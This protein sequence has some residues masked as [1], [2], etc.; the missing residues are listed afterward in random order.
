MNFC[1]KQQARTN[2]EGEVF[3][4]KASCSAM[5]QV[6]PGTKH[7]LS[8]KQTVYALLDSGSTSSF[9][10]TQLA[11]RLELKPMESSDVIRRGFYSPNNHSTM[12]VHFQILDANDSG[13]F[14]CQ[15][16]LVVEDFE[17]PKL[18]EDPTDIIKKYHHL[19]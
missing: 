15:N 12:T 8:Q 18:K 5:V 11:K 6:V 13:R 4:T 3:A 16:I 9:M 10:S 14:S 2:D 1:N 7:S 19:N 17:L